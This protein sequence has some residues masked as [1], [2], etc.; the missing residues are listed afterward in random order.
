[1]SDE[2]DRA[3]AGGYRDAVALLRL[4]R[5]AHADHSHV[6]ALTRYALNLTH[7][8]LR[9]SAI[10]LAALFTLNVDTDGRPF[11]EWLTDVALSV[12]RGTP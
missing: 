10:A 5:N 12:E 8:E 11:D 2:T 4:T 6:P 9:M 3:A 1:M 7:D